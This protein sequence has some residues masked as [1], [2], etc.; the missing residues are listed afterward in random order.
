M[1]YNELRFI[2]WYLDELQLDDRRGGDRQISDDS[3]EAPQQQ[4]V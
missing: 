4:A 1:E 3:P 2:S